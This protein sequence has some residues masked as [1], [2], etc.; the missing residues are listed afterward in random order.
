MT[1][2]NGPGVYH[3][4]EFAQW[5]RAQQTA[6]LE[7]TL[8]EKLGCGRSTLFRWAQGGSKPANPRNQQAIEV[9]H[10]ETGRLP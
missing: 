10:R 8:L 3:D 7:E 6:I 1:S 2:G 4:S 9:Y 5:I